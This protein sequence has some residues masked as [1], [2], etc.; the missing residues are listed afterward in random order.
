M[1]TQSTTPAGSNALRVETLATRLTAVEMQ[2]VGAAAESSAISRSEWLRDAAL[3]FW[4]NPVQPHI[5]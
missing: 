4:N 2:A 1:K 3:A 5:R